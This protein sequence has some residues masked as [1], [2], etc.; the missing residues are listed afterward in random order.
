MINIQEL[1]LIKMQALST[2]QQKS[3][4]QFIDQITSSED[5]WESMIE[6]NELMK[7]PDLLQ[8]V[9]TARQEYQKGETLSMEQ[10]FG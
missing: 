10:I 1:V 4:L 3:V 6:T 7:I 8:Q 2:D 5:N 9:K